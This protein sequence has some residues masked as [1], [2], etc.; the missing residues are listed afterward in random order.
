LSRWM[1]RLPIPSPFVPSP[2]LPLR[3]VFDIRPPRDWGKG[4]CGEGWGRNWVDFW[5]EV[6]Y[7]RYNGY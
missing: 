5:G 3:T 2:N 4:G 7:I 1:R 6:W